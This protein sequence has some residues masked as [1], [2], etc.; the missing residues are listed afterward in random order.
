ILREKDE[1]AV[2][3]TLKQFLIMGAFIVLASATAFAQ[4]DDEQKKPKPK[5]SPPIV[6][7]PDGGKK[8]KGNERPPQ[9]PQ[10]E[11]TETAM[12]PGRFD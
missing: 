6:V 11:P 1:T 2:M 12:M 5:P 9:K 3:K 10:G 8:P 7:V 4:K